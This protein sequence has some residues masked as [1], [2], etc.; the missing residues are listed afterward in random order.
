[1]STPKDCLTNLKCCFPHHYTCTNR[2][3]VART[4]IT[5]Q[6][7]ILEKFWP[8]FRLSLLLGLLSFIFL[9]SILNKVEPTRYVPME[10][11]NFQTANRSELSTSGSKSIL[12]ILVE[13]ADI[14]HTLQPNDIK[15]SFDRMAMY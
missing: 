8:S 13:F 3:K 4:G 12:C 2:V 9:P 1:M 5:I 14:S 11:A 6:V 10:I 7:P 15:T